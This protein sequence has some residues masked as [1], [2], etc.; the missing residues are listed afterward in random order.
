MIVTFL[1]YEAITNFLN[2]IN[3]I[4]PLWLCAIHRKLFA[5]ISCAHSPAGHSCAHPQ[6][7]IEQ[8]TMSEIIENVIC[9]NKTFQPNPRIK[10]LNSFIGFQIALNFMR[11]S[12]SFYL[13]TS[14]SHLA[15]QLRL[16]WIVSDA[17]AHTS[18]HTEPPRT[19]VDFVIVAFQLFEFTWEK[20]RDGKWVNRL[21]Y[22]IMSL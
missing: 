2:W 5:I 10:H 3:C 18:S 4:F 13:L 14:F 8:Q 17:S 6:H 19:Q 21:K 7:C 15:E 16:E 1:F 12:F 20:R 9:T 22:S 11:Q